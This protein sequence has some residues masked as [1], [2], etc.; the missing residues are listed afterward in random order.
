[1]Y[2]TLEDLKMTG[3]EITAVSGA[4]VALMCLL[5][6]S[7]V[8]RRWAP[9]LVAVLSALAIGTW[10]YARGTISQADTFNYVSAWI[11]V[12]TS[13]ATVWGFSWAASGDRPSKEA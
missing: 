10:A 2:R 7:G 6:W 8:P 5:R 12:A 4:V 11:A 13:A 1:L 9:G 3:L